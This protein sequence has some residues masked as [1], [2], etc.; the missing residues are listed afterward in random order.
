MYDVI[1]LPEQ[2]FKRARYYLSGEASSAPQLTLGKSSAVF[3]PF[4]TRQV[5]V[6]AAAHH[7]QSARDYFLPLFQK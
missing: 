1:M 6:K 3:I 7:A 2:E 4:D 5:R